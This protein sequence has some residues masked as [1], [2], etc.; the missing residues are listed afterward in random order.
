[1]SDSKQSAN[2]ELRHALRLCMEQMCERCREAA[3]A[4]TASIPCLTGC[5]IKKIAKAA[6][7]EPPRNCDLYTVG[8]ALSK[9]GFPT[10]IKQWG[11][12]E[13]IDFCEWLVSEAKGAT[14]EQ[15]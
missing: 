9:Y 15:K 6:L 10:K 8:K 12:K 13:W 14:D 4:L 7:A 2:E 5:E 11:E 3:D 1:M